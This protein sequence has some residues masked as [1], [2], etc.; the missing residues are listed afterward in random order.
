[1]LV[2]QLIW[3]CANK[4]ANSN[5]NNNT[6]NNT[7]KRTVLTL[8]VIN[9]LVIINLKIFIFTI[10]LHTFLIHLKCNC[11]EW[12]TEWMNE[13]RLFFQ[14]GKLN[15]CHFTYFFHLYRIVS[16]KKKTCFEFHR[17]TI[18]YQCFNHRCLFI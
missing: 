13:W 14:K 6:N 4:N 7:Q 15:F 12:S 8:A 16:C 5:N 11:Y 2:T 1:M 10:V 9:S 3:L 17:R 18:L